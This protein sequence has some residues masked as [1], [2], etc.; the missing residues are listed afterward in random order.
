MYFDLKTS[1]TAPVTARRGATAHEA[2]TELPSVGQRTS[3]RT[4]CTRRVQRLPDQALLDLLERQGVEFGSSVASFSSMAS[5]G[6][7]TVLA[8]W[9]PLLPLFLVLRRI[10]GTRL[11]RRRRVFACLT[12]GNS[13]AGSERMGERRRGPATQVCARRRR[14]SRAKAAR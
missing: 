9:L 11:V 8:L 5:R 12:S 10:T 14:T 7:L 1:P 4:Y 3:P 2:A 6:L 13:I